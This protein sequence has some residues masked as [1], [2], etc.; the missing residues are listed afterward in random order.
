MKRTTL[1]I[2]F[3]TLAACNGGDG[4]VSAGSA[5]SVISEAASTAKKRMGREG[6][7]AF[8]VSVDLTDAYGNPTQ[9]EALRF[10]WLVVTRDQI[11][12]TSIDEYQLIDLASVEI[13]SAWGQKAFAEWCDENGVTLTPRLCGPE[14]RRAEASWTTPGP[15]QPDGTSKTA[16]DGLIHE[17]RV[18]IGGDL[19]DARIVQSANG[20]GRAVC[21]KKA[22][23][24]FVYQE[25][26]Q[27][28]TWANTSEFSRSGVEGWCGSDTTQS[29]KE[30]AD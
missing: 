10:S 2:A 8:V 20:H 4:P 1:S 23:V 3:L 7:D 24:A 27:K 25:G 6:P 9:Q 11:N 28:P 14:R 15:I 29:A 26:T 17:A 19:T 21:G 5:K 18:A 13:R 12:R 16:E 30:A 22:G